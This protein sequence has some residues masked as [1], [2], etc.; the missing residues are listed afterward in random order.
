MKK[1]LL[2]IF[3]I[4]LSSIN[5]QASTLSE[6]I[7][8]SPVTHAVIG[9]VVG[10]LGYQVLSGCNVNPLVHFTQE[11]NGEKF[12]LLGVQSMG[13]CA[14]IYEKYAQQKLSDCD[15]GFYDIARFTNKKVCTFKTPIVLINSFAKQHHDN[16]S[17][18]VG[19]ALLV[20]LR[21]LAMGLITGGLAYY[22]AKK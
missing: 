17:E 4:A 10:N 11:E 22:A 5:I 21:P 18:E 15:N 2:A 12:D 13:A 8:Q 16:G 7:I 9:Y 14:Y 1:N 3:L 6:T 19:A 20:D